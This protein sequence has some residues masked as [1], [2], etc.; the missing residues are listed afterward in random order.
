MVSKGYEK[1]DAHDPITSTHGIDGIYM[2]PGP[3]K[4]Y[5]IIEAKYD[6]STLKMTEDGIQMTDNWIR[7]RI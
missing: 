7:K 5:V 6:R 3:P 4:E 1:I 2:K